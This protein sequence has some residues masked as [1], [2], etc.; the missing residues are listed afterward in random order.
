MITLLTC[1]YC[2]DVRVPRGKGKQGT[3]TCGDPRCQKKLKSE[4]AKSSKAKESQR[5]LRKR[6]RDKVREYQKQYSADPK[7]KERYRELSKGYRAKSKHERSKKASEYYRKTVNPNAK[8]YNPWSFTPKDERQKKQKMWRKANNL[9]RRSNLSVLKNTIQRVYE[10]NIK[11]YGTLTCYLCLTP[12]PFGNDN[13]EH[14]IPISRGGSNDYINLDIS[15]Q[16]CN[17][18]KQSKT[19]PEYLHY[20]KTKAGYTKDGTRS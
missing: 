10:D 4:H 14:K 1:K 18:E 5:E 19:V 16:E 9:A 6:N 15:C 8:E 3:V 7:H 17:W 11:R 2:G 13:L 20:K 12:I